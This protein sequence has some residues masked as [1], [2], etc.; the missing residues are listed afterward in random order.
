MSDNPVNKS[1]EEEEEKLKEYFQFNR[2][3]SIE[4][5]LNKKRYIR[6]FC[7]LG[8]LILII[9]L[10]IVIIVVSKKDDEKEINC[11]EGYFLPNDSNGK[12]CEK[13]LLNN[14]RKCS[15]SLN[16]NIYEECK[17]NFFSIKEN[18]AIKSCEQLCNLDANCLDCNNQTNHCNSCNSKTFL[19]N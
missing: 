18:E 10:I 5:K 11:E 1:K 12:N 16:E 19:I 14:C 2:F 6:I 7:I 9:I 15:G 4:L 17:S 8:V 3:N 13:C